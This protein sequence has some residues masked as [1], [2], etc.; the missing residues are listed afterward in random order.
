MRQ[1]ATF[2]P[3]DSSKF[4]TKL[5]YW[6]ST[7]EVFAFLDSHG[8]AP[9]LVGK[10]PEL[11]VAAGVVSA[12]SCPA[13]EAFGALEKFQS[14]TRDWLFGGFGYGLKNE[15]EQL[16]SRHQDRIGFPD[17]FFFQP[18]AVIK[19]AGA[20]VEIQVCGHS[21]E[22]IFAAIEEQVIPVPPQTVQAN[23][24]LKPRI[25]KSDYLNIVGQIKEHIAAGDV[26]EMNFC[27][28]FYAENARINVLDTWAKLSELS[29]A[30]MS[31][32]LRWYSRHLLCAS[33]ERFIKKEGH[34]LI[35]Q[36]I[37]G[38]RP[39][40]PGQDEILRSE[41]ANSEKDQAENVMIVDLVR[42]DLART[43]VPGTVKVEELFGIHSFETVHQMISTVTGV[44]RPEVQGIDAIR[45]SF[46]PGSMTGAPKVMAM[47][48]IE[49]YESSKRGLY[50]GAVG[51]FDPQGNFD[52]N[53]VI[54]SIL[55]DAARSYV[56]FQV[57]GAIVYDSVPEEE[58]QECLVKA[59]AM[60]RALGV[61]SIQL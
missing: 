2:I 51:Y 19:V 11:L 41:L 10:G 29:H 24:G 15:T 34:K 47:Q 6:A 16:S 9:H 28:E 43:C 13:G 59:K 18:V 3:A 38:T 44:L 17:L 22:S 40:I 14:K 20:H 4:K 58:Y 12:I 52:F 48:L 55:Y 37:K 5:L 60:F 21:P 25:P 35:S 7:H 31:A 50:S 53:V 27:Q 26:Y 36:P 32:Y 33:P 42:N 23:I 39:R 57:G 54:R 61:D 30:P 49:Q 45:H 1:S 8:H 46:P 56:S